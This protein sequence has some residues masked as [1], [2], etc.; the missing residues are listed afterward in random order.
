MK[1]SEIYN[2]Q[3]LPLSRIVLNRKTMYAGEN[4]SVSNSRVKENSYT[5]STK[6][7]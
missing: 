7:Q 5:N 2:V 3:P 4:G 1:L 6:V